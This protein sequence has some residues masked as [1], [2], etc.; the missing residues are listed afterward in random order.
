MLVAFSGYLSELKPVYILVSITNLCISIAPLL[1]LGYTEQ[2][3]IFPFVANHWLDYWTRI[4]DSFN[5]KNL[6]LQFPKA[7]VFTVLHMIVSA[8]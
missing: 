8:Q 5:L 3:S 2:S 1:C 4:T 7:D 6:V